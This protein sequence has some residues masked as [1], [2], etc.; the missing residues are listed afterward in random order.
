MSTLIKNDVDEIR[1]MALDYI[2]RDW[3][4]RGQI[5]NLSKKDWTFS[6]NER[7]RA[8]GL[9]SPRSKTIYLSQWFIENGSRETSMWVN[10]MI[11]EIAHAINYHLGGRG[12]DRQWRN[13]F[14]SL[15][16]NGQRTSGD[17]KFQDLIENPVSKY[18]TICPNGHT[19]PSH[20]KSKAISNG[21]R[22]CGKCC[23]T[24]NKDFLLKQI[25]NY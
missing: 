20:K 10:T 19:S 8:L 6:F 17:I 1:D 18:T 2:S 12:H 15:G 4:Y 21:R 9:C 16:G 3:I 24:F 7:R 25:Q 22:S 14:I 5:F 11:H 13:I 23:N